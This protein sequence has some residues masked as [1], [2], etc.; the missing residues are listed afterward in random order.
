MVGKHAKKDPKYKIQS[1]GNRYLVVIASS[2]KQVPGTPTYESQTDASAH[3][4][5]L[6]K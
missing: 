4:A 1:K 6:N 3:A 5:R 2:G